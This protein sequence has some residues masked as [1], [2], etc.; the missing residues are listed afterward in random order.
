M[1]WRSPL[2][3]ELGVHA[4][5]VHVGT[6]TVTCTAHAGG[7]L[8]TESLGVPYAETLP[9][10]DVFNLSSM[11]RSLIAF[12]PVITVRSL[13]CLSLIF[14]NLKLSATPIY[15]SHFPSC[16]VRPLSH[17][18]FSCFSLYHFALFPTYSS[19]LPPR[20]CRA[21]RP[22]ENARP[23][24]TG[25]SGCSTANVVD[26]SRTPQPGPPAMAAVN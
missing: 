1:L 23:V 10:V 14:R 17:P 16:V 21:A 6:L 9:P 7:D 4:E 25:S 13:L 18:R 8:M 5:L 11:L 26:H 15:A 22:R 2:V 20:C 24:R 12:A 3:F 19:S